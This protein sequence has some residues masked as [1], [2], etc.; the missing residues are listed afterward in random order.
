MSRCRLTSQLCDIENAQSPRGKDEVK[1]LL[2]SVNW[3]LPSLTLSWAHLNFT[4]PLLRWYLNRQHMCRCHQS[5]QKRQFNSAQLAQKPPFSPFKCLFISFFL[6]PLSPFPSSFAI[7]NTLLPWLQFSESHEVQR[8]A[9][10]RITT[11]T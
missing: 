7:T 4:C 10:P 1:L 3:P 5:A 6:P 11:V 2:T 8:K 9:P